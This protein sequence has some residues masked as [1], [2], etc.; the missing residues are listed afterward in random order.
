MDHDYPHYNLH[1]SLKVVHDCHMWYF[2]VVFYH[3]CVGGND[4]LGNDEA[5]N[6]V[7]RTHYMFPY[8]YIREYLQFQVVLLN[9]F[10]LYDLL[11]YL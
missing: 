8:C 6:N 10:Q 4:N 2:S 11:V 5:N 7:H 3:H 1:W 9:D